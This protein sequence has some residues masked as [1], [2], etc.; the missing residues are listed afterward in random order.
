MHCPHHLAARLLATAL[1]SAGRSNGLPCG[2]RVVPAPL[3]AV[4]G[5]AADAAATQQLQAPEHP[6]AAQAAGAAAA[7]QPGSSPGPPAHPPS[8]S[9]GGGGAPTATTLGSPALLARVSATLN[10]LTGYEAID[11]LKGRVEEV[12][13]QLQD[14]KAQ[15]ADAKAAYDALLA[16]QARLH[17]CVAAGAARCRCCCCCFGS[18]V[19]QQA[20]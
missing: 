20:V 11:Q 7:L 16:T 17:R 4:R 12:H 1:C 5:L 19:L 8:S 15:L 2:V 14:G 10:Q 6:T 13:R 9:G 18:C 3:Q